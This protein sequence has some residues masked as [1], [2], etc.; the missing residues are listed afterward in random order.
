[1]ILLHANL[2]A[3]GQRG[4]GTVPRGPTLPIR[5]TGIPQQSAAVAR[6]R[7]LRFLE[8]HPDVPLHALVCSGKN[9]PGTGGPPK[10]YLG[11]P[12]RP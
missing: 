8:R 6:D 3:A 10:R 4:T 12:V 1:M 9:R 5:S 11:G 2:R 7:H